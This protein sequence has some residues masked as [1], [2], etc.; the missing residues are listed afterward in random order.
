MSSGIDGWK[1]IH[2]C[3][4]AGALLVEFRGAFVALWKIGPAGKAHTDIR[5]G[6]GAIHDE[7][8]TPTIKNMAMGIGKSYE[9]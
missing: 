4:G 9:T 8:L 1:D 3:T 2:A 5:L 6:P 7:I